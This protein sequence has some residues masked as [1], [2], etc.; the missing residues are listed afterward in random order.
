[1]DTFTFCTLIL[2]VLNLLFFIIL[3]KK[4]KSLKRFDKCMMFA[5]DLAYFILLFSSGKNF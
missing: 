5:L 3:A 4:P 1:M 2:I